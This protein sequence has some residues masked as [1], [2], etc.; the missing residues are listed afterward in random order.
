MDQ[1]IH[2]WLFDIKEAIDEI[3]SFFDGKNETLEFYKSSTMLRRATERNIEIIGEAVNRI[4]KRDA[5]YKSKITKVTAIIAL[6]NEIINVY[7]GV[8]DEL[9]W[10]ILIHHLPILKKEIDTL[11]EQA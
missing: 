2:K 1:R 7:D 6:R 11:L 10:S 8:S 3:E 9:I 4:I 5:L